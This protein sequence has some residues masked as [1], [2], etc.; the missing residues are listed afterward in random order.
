MYR[1]SIY[2]HDVWKG[3]FVVGNKIIDIT[4]LSEENTM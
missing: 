2:T 3:D 4:L 1:F